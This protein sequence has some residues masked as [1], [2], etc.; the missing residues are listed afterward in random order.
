MS[1]YFDTITEKEAIQYFRDMWNWLAKPENAMSEKLDWPR[2]DDVVAHAFLLGYDDEEVWEEVADNA[3]CFLCVLATREAAKNSDFF[4]SKDC[5]HFCPVNWNDP[6][7]SF[8]GQ[9]SNCCC[10]R[11]EEKGVPV[12]EKG[13]YS[14]WECEE[15]PEERARLAKVIANLPLREEWRIK[16]S[17]W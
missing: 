4:S 7:R 11:L 2:W 15:D 10:L 1:K 5:E 9:I 12:S 14:L 8:L 17:E 3:E 16:E 13:F 6:N